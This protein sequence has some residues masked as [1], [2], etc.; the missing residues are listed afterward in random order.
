[1]ANAGVQTLEVL[2]RAAWWII[3][4]IP[5]IVM[6]IVRGIRSLIKPANNAQGLKQNREQDAAY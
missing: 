1:M 6:A 4:L 5:R 2:V 3:K